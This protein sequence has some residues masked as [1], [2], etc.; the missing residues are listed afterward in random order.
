MAEQNSNLFKTE[1]EISDQFEGQDMTYVFRIPT[2]MEMAKIGIVARNLRKSDDPDGNGS[3]EGLDDLSAT[4]YYA[5]ANFIV[6][7]VRGD[8]NWVMTP[9]E[10]GNPECNPGNWGMDV[11]FLRIFEKFIQELERFREGRNKP[12]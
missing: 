11:P 4:Y 10:G 7:Y 6:L 3:D 9:D 8:N 1:I 5:F 12:V 2:P